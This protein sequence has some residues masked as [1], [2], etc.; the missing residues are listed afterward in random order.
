MINLGQRPNQSASYI[1]FWVYT[2]DANRTVASTAID[3][4]DYNRIRPPLAFTQQDSEGLQLIQTIYG[5]EI[6]ADSMKS[7][8]V[9]DE[10]TG[11][12]KIKVYVGDR[13]MYH[14]W[15]ENA[16]HFSIYSQ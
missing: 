3:Y 14:A 16:A 4:R 15:N 7:R 11:D 10:G 2:D 8:P 6:K 9:I 5:E 12:T 1:E 13:F